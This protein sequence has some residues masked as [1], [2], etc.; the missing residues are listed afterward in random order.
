MLS[1]N[2]PDCDGPRRLRLRLSHRRQTRCQRQ[3]RSGGANSG[4][5]PVHTGFE[6]Q[7]IL[8]KQNRAVGVRAVNVHTGK[9]LTVK[10]NMVLLACGS[11]FTP[12]LLMKNKLANSSGQVGKNLSVHPAVGV[13]ARMPQEVRGWESIPQG[14]QVD[15]FHEDG[16]LY[17]GSTLPFELHALINPALGM[18]MQEYMEDFAHLASFG[19]LISDTSRGQVRPHPILKGSPLM[20][21]KMNETDQKKVKRG[22]RILTDIYFAA[23][24][25][26]GHA[27]DPLGG[28]APKPGAG[29]CVLRCRFSHSQYGAERVSSPG[30]RCAWAAIRVRRW[31]TPTARA[32]TCAT[33]SSPTAPF[34]REAPPSTRMVTICAFAHRI[35]RYMDSRLRL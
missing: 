10:A 24:A 30:G 19:F 14:Y 3:L 13:N 33:C 12:L 18:E 20:L 8:T 25:E 21:Y 28:K 9:T 11:L 7:E 34:Y 5:E 31:W 23:G 16:L 4:S 17:E 2:A 22:L 15:E 1:R 32:S 29:A 26:W 35:A 6:V 27:A